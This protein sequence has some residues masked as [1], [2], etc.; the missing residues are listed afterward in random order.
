VEAGSYQPPPEGGAA[1]CELS[2]LWVLGEWE[3]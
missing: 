3:D 1:E 2:G